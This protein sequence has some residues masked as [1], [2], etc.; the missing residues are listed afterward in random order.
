MPLAT[1]VNLKNGVLSRS[2]VLQGTGDFRVMRDAISVC[3]STEIR[4]IFWYRLNEIA[5]V[6]LVIALEKLQKFEH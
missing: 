2:P 1:G 4:T 6:E 3:L 5:L